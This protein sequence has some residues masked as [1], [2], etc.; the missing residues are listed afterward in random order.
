MNVFLI[1]KSKSLIMSIEETV[2]EI[3]RLARE[4]N[5]DGIYYYSEMILD[6]IKSNFDEEKFYCN[7]I[8]KTLFSMKHWMNSEK[9]KNHIFVLENFKK[10][11]EIRSKVS[12]LFPIHGREIFVFEKIFFPHIEN[13]TDCIVKTLQG[14]NHFQ[15][16]D[17]YGEDGYV[18]VEVYFHRRSTW[19]Q[20]I[21]RNTNP[22]ILIDALM[23]LGDYEPKINYDCVYKHKICSFCHVEFDD[24]NKLHQCRFCH[25]AACYRCAKF[26]VEHMKGQC[27]EG[28]RKTYG[29]SRSFMHELLE[30][31][32]KS[33]IPFEEWKEKQI[34]IARKSKLMNNL[35][36]HILYN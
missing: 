14:L 3:S 33:G 24:E 20:K 11:C 8:N 26:G 5:V 9:Y 30:E 7:P 15:L 32:C 23:K 25:D 16:I 10:I 2:N 17:I 31:G 28:F 35:K 36:K 1:E 27:H 34:Q 22:D 18:V 6:F 21:K 4:E 29:Y 12:K 19:Q 13:I